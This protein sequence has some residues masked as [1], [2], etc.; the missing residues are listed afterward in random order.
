[1]RFP[2]E[3]YHHLGEANHFD[4]LNHPAIYAQMRRCL[5]SQRAL[6]ASQRP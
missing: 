1:M 3:H 4:L 5:G 2:I 6:P